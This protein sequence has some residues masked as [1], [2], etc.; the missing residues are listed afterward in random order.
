MEW[1]IWHEKII[2]D[3]FN[4]WDDPLHKNSEI[5]KT[6][7]SHLNFNN[8]EPVEKI[9]ITLRNEGQEITGSWWGKWFRRRGLIT[10]VMDFT[11]RKYLN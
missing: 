1:Q 8:N 3:I 7:I 4:L 11:V 6:R 10:T 5:E 2:V 9:R